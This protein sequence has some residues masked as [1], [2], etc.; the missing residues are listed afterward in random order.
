MKKFILLMWLAAGMLPAAA[1]DWIENDNPGRLELD[2]GLTYHVETQASAS[3]GKTPLWLNANKHGL[4]SLKEWNGY[5]RAGVERPL[6][7]DSARRWAVGYG[8]DMVVPTGYTSKV[9]V[10]QAYGEVRWLHGLLSVGAKEYP[11]ELKNNLLS[12]GSQTLGINARP[13]PQVRIALPDYWKLPFANGWLHVKGHVAYGKMT[14]QNWQ[15]EFTQRQSKYADGVLYHSKAGYLKIGNEDLF[16]PFSIELGLEMASQF[17]GT[18]YE[19]QPDKTLQPL[20]TESFVK[21]AWH[22]FFPG[23]ADAGETLYQNVSGNQLGSWLMRLNYD[24][25]FWRASLYVDR[26]FEDHSAMLFVDYDGYGEGDEWQKKKKRRYFFYDLTDWMVGAE[27][28]LKQGTWLRNMVVEFLHTKYQSG[29]VYHDHTPL[30]AD[31]LGGNDN[32]YNHYIYTGWQ[33]WGQ[34]MGNPLYRSPIYNTDGCIE[35][36]NNRFMALH[37]GFDGQPTERLSYR[38]MASWQDGLGSYDIPFLEKRHNT[39]FM[40]ESGYAFNHGWHLRA[41][42]GMDFGSI[43]GHN[44]GAQVTFSKRGLL[45]K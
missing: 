43:L 14:D 33:H 23:G 24:T 5:L 2:R 6:Q 42:Y 16:I 1:Q 35:V 22:A 36:E 19:V 21:G 31:H 37:I 15:H 3:E 20:Q 18:P 32:Y 4:S 29:P 7:Q 38:V 12:S 26:F 39:S 27:L 40:V 41:A 44:Y 10:Q 9:V 28:N 17:G 30:I 13:V 25:D 45:G 8:V 34:V 11:M